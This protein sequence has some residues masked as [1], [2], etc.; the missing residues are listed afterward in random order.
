MSTFVSLDTIF[1]NS[2][3]TTAPIKEPTGPPYIAPIAPVT[4]EENST[5]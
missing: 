4:V 3:P 5:R 2:A 1:P